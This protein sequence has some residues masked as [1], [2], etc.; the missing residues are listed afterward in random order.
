MVS[1]K[2]VIGLAGMPGSGKSLVLNTALESGYTIVVMG[3]IIREETT[4]RGLEPNPANMGQ[5]MLK[6][7]E[8]EGKG[9]VAKACIPRIDNAKG[10]KVFVD[11]LRSLEEAE[12]FKKNFPSFTLMAIHSSPETRFGRLLRRKRSDDPADW[13]T[14]HERDSRELGVGLGNTIAMAE[15]I[16]VNEQDINTTR[17]SIR[18]TFR[19]VEAKWKE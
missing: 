5:V 13:K 6:L 3:D 2:L 17:K 4:K 15:H 14:F 16:I 18:E 12:E 9:V 8:E 10:Q 7:R 1:D 11:G 19:K